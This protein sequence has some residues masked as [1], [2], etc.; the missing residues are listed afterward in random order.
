ML[1]RQINDDCTHLHCVRE[2][3]G[4]T[5]LKIRQKWQ[6][7]THVNK[8]LPTESFCRVRILLHTYSHIHDIK[9]NSEDTYS[10]LWPHSSFS[11]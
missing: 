3:V 7:W 11:R 1:L 9:Y 5:P 6:T 10:K 4:L 8:I 2:K